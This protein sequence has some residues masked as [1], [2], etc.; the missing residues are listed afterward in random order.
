MLKNRQACRGRV[1]VC[2]CLMGV[3]RLSFA[4]AVT[5][6]SRATAVRD[7]VLRRV[8]RYPWDGGSLHEASRHSI[9]S[10]AGLLDAVYVRP[11]EAA[12]RAALLICHGIGETVE[13]WREVQ[14]LLAA[15]GVASLVFDYCGYGKSKGAVDWSQFEQD[16]I[17]AFAFLKQ[18]RPGAPVSL[19][20]FSM[21]SGIATAILE[22]T[23]PERL[24]LCAAF[25]SF[26]D[27]ACSLGVPRRFSSV[28][29]AI[30]SG[31]EPLRQWRRP[32][33]IVHGERD[34]TFPVQMASRLADWSGENAELVVVP[35]H[36]HNEPFY[37][38]QLCYWGEIVAR[39]APEETS[40]SAAVIAAEG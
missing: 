36:A 22:R 9:A 31:E 19:L 16:A 34:R 5:L 15:Q 13:H 17:A 3:E 37:R 7:R 12:P 25:T 2:V 23:D 10:G 20:G 18:L 11:V 33:L 28:M 8:G 30:W 38:P 6:I 29:P 14:N 4:V 21:G 40:C 35:N 26:R 24:V 32:V 27:A 39:L 1:R